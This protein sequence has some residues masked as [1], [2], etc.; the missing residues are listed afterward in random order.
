MMAQALRQTQGGQDIWALGVISLT[1][2]AGLDA[3]TW[4]LVKQ[5]AEVLQHLE[6]LLGEIDATVWPG[7]KQLPLWSLSYQSQFKCDIV[8]RGIYLH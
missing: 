7:Y 5:P 3:C 4:R 1:L 8:G 2:G 6:E